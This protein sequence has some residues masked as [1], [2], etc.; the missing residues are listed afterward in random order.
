MSIRGHQDDS[1]SGVIKSTLADKGRDAIFRLKDLMKFG[2]DDSDE[3]KPQNPSN[4]QRQDI[5]QNSVEN[6]HPFYPPG[7][8]TQDR[9]HM[10]PTSIFDEIDR[11]EREFFG[12]FMGGGPQIPS[13]QNRFDTDLS[14]G[15][16]SRR[17]QMHDKFSGDL[18]SH[19]MDELRREFGFGGFGDIGPRVEV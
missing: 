8:F 18:Q 19:M 11:M 1:P 14:I 17:N 16:L 15:S 4:W 5:S 12:G 2:S 13:M 3:N 10:Q 9:R 6:G 7:H